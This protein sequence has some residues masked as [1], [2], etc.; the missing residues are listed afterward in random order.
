[1]PGSGLPVA[2]RKVTF[3]GWLRPGGAAGGGYFSRAAF[4]TEATVER[5]SRRTLSRRSSPNLSPRKECF[6]RHTWR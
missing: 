4:Q 5:V 3:Y 2:D 1:M 6:W